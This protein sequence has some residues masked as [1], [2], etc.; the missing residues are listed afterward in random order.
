MV[1]RIIDVAG[2]ADTAAQGNLVY[3]HLHL[4][5]QT[6]CSETVVSFEGIQTATSSFV[7]V[8]FVKLLDDWPLAEIKRRFEKPR[9]SHKT[10]LSL[11]PRPPFPMAARMLP[12]P[13]R[14]G[15][16]S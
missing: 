3:P 10:G 5:L 7:N 1:I 12:T 4:A 11:G 13:N 9:R 16:N 2:S 15:A 8:S 14:P 6:R